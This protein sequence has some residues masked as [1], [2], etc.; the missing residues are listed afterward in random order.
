MKKWMITYSLLS[1]FIGFCLSGHPAVVAN[2]EPA[3]TNLPVIVEKKIPFENHS[4]ADGQGDYKRIQVG[5]RSTAPSI[6]FF[7][8]AERVYQVPGTLY[9]E[10][11]S[12]GF[13][14]KEIV[15]NRLQHLFPSHYFW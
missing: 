2:Y 3:S 4:G 15:R 12:A 7:F 5:P 8:L 9:R 14:K 1:L 11:P 10:Q 13:E 6:P